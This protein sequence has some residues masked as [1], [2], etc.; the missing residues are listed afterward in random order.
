MHV[1][2][3]DAPPELAPPHVLLTQNNSHFDRTVVLVGGE[4]GGL[5]IETRK[6]N[7]V[8]SSYSS[9]SAFRQIRRQSRNNGAWS[10]KL[11]PRRP[12]LLCKFHA[13]LSN[14]SADSRS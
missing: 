9:R 14:R 4:S 5:K 1:P 10:A 3:R 13:T 7:H 12:E 2:R 8:R 11:S 6:A